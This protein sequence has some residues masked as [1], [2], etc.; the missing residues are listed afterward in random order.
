MANSLLRTDKEIAELYERHVKTVY[1]ICFS[2]LKNSSDTE[3]MVQDTFLKL[4]QYGGRFQDF[5]HEKAWLIVTSSNL[6]RNQLRHWWHKRRADLDTENLRGD[7][8]SFEIDETFQ[9][10]MYLPEKYKLAL[11]LYYYE[12][13]NSVETA[14]LMKKNES[15]V[16]GYLHTGRKLLKSKLGGAVNE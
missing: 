6:C 15:T 4:L 5:E 10:L 2:Y 7:A 12:G 9:A 8:I 16:R 13:Y 3:D 1:R 11:Y 14:K